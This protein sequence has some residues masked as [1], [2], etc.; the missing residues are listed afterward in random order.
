MKRMKLRF[1]I[2]AAF[3]LILS[4][5]LPYN[6]E[7]GSYSQ[8]IS[9]I[10]GKADTV[11]LK[12]DVADVLV[13]N[14]AVADVG[15]L[16]TDR[17]FIV[18]KSVGDTNVLAYDLVG[19]QLANI[20]VHVRV[21]DKTI[22]D[23]LR[24][25]FPNENIS[26]KT[27]KNNIV[28]SGKVSSASV[29]NQVRDL[30]SRF[31][32]SGDQTIVDLMSVKGEQQVMLKVKIVEVKRSALRELGVQTSIGDNIDSLTRGAGVDTYDIGRTATTPF[33]EAGLII[34]NNG[35]NWG[36][37]A[38]KLRAL[39]TQGLVNTLAEPT[40][41][42][43]SGETAGFLAGGE[44]PIPTGKDEDGNITI[45]FKPFG[46]S[47]NFTPTV[48]TEKRIALH[49]STEVSEKDTTNGLTMAG[50]QIDG[51]SVRRAQTT[52]ELGS[53]NTIMIAGLIKS[54]T[55]DGL[56]GMPGVQNLPIL[57]ELF[58]SKSFQR[59]ESELLIMVTPYMVKSYAEPEAVEKVDAKSDLEARLEELRS[60]DDAEST[61]AQ[62]ANDN[63]EVSLSSTKPTR[64]I[65]VPEVEA[66]KMLGV[67]SS[68]K[69]VIKTAK[70]DKVRKS[71]VVKKQDGI[72]A[73]G[74]IKEL[75]SAYGSHMP[76]NINGSEKVGYI[77]D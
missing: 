74:F 50:I 7:S 48:M 21:D 33:G 14:P 12:G 34:G 43:I 10:Q 13:A 20:S 18:G 62:Q 77:V 42:A 2:V 44:Y 28:L 70:E 65:K 64:V 38:V 31:L 54:N 67:S 75:R 57:G 1:I 73:K 45:E 22:Q 63:R 47:L 68:S 6:A 53:G 55:L 5:V 17:L 46:V 60:E 76:E 72:L 36:P 59:N 66:A 58:K 8:T 41:T 16:R 35:Q 56:N 26:A 4:V 3:A 69:P 24:S 61:L 15:S 9:V 52:V 39:E 11:Q 19:N 25:F 40:L 51:L 23:S 37:L 30:A 71:R 32:T 49:M 27:V 29:S